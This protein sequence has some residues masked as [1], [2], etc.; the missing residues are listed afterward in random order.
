MLC[1][2]ARLW[3]RSYSAPKTTKFIITNL[4]NDGINGAGHLVGFI[5]AHIMYLVSWFVWYMTY[6]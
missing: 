4:F 5:F 1:Y 6:N 3:V 2:Y